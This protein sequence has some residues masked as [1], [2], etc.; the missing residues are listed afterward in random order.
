LVNLRGATYPNL[1]P[2][3]AWNDA[4]LYDDALV[5][6]FISHRGPNGECRFLG[7]YS[8]DSTR[9]L[10]DAERDGF[11]CIPLEQWTWDLFLTLQFFH[12]L[13]LTL[14]FEGKFR[15]GMHVRAIGG[16]PVDWSGFQR[17]EEDANQGGRLWR[18]R[19]SS[20]GLTFEAETEFPA[21]KPH[22]IEDAV[23]RIISDFSGVIYGTKTYSERMG[24]GT[25]D[26][27]RALI[28]DLDPK[29]VKEVVRAAREHL[30][31]HDDGFRI[32]MT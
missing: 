14:K 8:F 31:K 13:A 3:P 7:D 9:E 6:S 22:A 20:V 17:M 23:S 4:E 25:S 27:A 32:Q 10:T 19:D 12:R 29:S 26:P 30:E 5:F 24:N 11:G 15:V 2:S 18:V 1:Q 16:M 21:V 28:L